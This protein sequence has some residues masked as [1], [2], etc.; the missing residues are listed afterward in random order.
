MR[1]RDL[2]KAFT[3]GSA[4]IAAISLPKTIQASEVPQPETYKGW[5][6][7]WS[8]WKTRDNQAIQSG[9]WFAGQPDELLHFGYST[10]RGVARWAFRQHVFDMSLQPGWRLLTALNTPE[11][12]EELKARAYDALI[13]LIDGGGVQ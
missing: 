3:A 5:K 11:E 10:T 4:S 6:I 13:A 7:V 1:R 12:H 9:Y 8:G 2:L